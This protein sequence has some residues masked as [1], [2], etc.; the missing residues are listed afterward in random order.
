MGKKHYPPFTV[1]SYRFKI[2]NELEFQPMDELK[3]QPLQS[4]TCRNCKTDVTVPEGDSCPNCSLANVTF[5]DGTLW[6]T[7]QQVSFRSLENIPGRG[8]RI[9]VQTK[10]DKLLYQAFECTDEHGAAIMFD[11]SHKVPCLTNSEISIQFRGPPNARRTGTQQ[12]RYSAVQHA[13]RTAKSAVWEW[14]DESGDF[15]PFADKVQEVLEDAFGS[16]QPVVCLEIGRH[17]YDIDTANMTQ[18]NVKYG[19]ARNIRRSRR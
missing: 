11:V 12:D 6:W 19:T 5:A 17:T 3:G 4:R 9:T 2:T 13:R 10:D 1:G 8:I 18:K 16:N 14:E 15:Q 7:M